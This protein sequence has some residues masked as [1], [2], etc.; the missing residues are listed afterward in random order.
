MMDLREELFNNQDIEYRDFHAKLT[1][2][3]DKQRIIGVRSPV[4]R[5]IAKRY[6]KEGGE[7]KLYYD[8]EIMVEG[9][10]IG[11]RKSS[12]DTYISE[13]REFVPLIDNWAV[14]DSCCSTY[15]FTKKYKKEMWDFIVSFIGKGEYQTRFAVVMLMDYYIEDEYIDRVCERII[16]I[17]SDEYYVNMAIAWAVS[18]IYIKM[19]EKGE[20]IINSRRLSSWVHNKAIQKICESYRVSN[21]DKLRLKSKKIKAN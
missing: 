5:Q 6:A 19:K 4:I 2:N 13:L 3:I 9:M 7:N 17:K 16:K 14:C 15:K 21:D 18:I 10:A 11:Y 12:I 1:P 8:E 20:E